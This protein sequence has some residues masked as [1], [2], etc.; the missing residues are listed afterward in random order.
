M[1]DKLKNIKWLKDKYDDFRINSIHKAIIQQS[2][3][4][5]DGD[6]IST[7]LTDQYGTFKVD[8]IYLTRKVRA[9]HAFQVSL[10]DRVGLDH[11]K[12]KKIVDFGD[13]S[14]QHLLYTKELLFKL[15]DILYIGV[16]IDKGALKKI[17]EKGFIPI[18]YDIEEAIFKYEDF[19]DA[20]YVY[21]FETLE[22]LNNP[23]T[24]LRKIKEDINP[25]AL[26]ITVPYVRKSRVGIEKT[27][28]GKTDLTPEDVHI[29]ELSPY[30]WKQLFTYAGW[31][32]NYEQIYY[33]YPEKKEGLITLSRSLFYRWY[34]DR[35]DYEG[36]AGFILCK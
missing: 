18:H 3:I 14:G 9:L 34:W 7:D 25:K 29:F 15:R 28:K 13:S 11:P 21:M 26:I 27:S 19:S 5:R 30:D 31:T 36:F 32:I 6:V 33:Q 4:K 23:G 12:V 10:I 8:D 17:K 20:D 1:K 24:V 2:L 16:N 22:H 35:F